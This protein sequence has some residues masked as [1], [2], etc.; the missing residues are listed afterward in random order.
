MTQRRGASARSGDQLSNLGL[1]RNPSWFT[2]LA[3][4][5]AG[6]VRLLNVDGTFRQC[7]ANCALVRRYLEPAKYRCRDA[8][9]PQK[10][11]C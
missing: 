4:G 11:Y 7:R 5:N 3:A 8:T 10:K 6:A 2:Q 9:R 1:P